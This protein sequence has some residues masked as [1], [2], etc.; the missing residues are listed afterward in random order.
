MSTF[1][2]ELCLTVKAGNGGPGCV[3]FRHEKFVEYGGPDGGDG[4]DGGNL[5]LQSTKILNSLSHLKPEKTYKAGSGSHGMGV[6]RSGKKGQD[7][8][9]E[10]PLGTQL[11]DPET[12]TVLHDFISEEKYVLAEGARGGKGNAFF[13]SATRQAPRFA[14]PGE[15]TESFEIVLRLKLIAEIGFV[16]L[17]NAGK[18]SLLSALTNAKPETAPYPFTTISPN[19]GVIEDAALGRVTLAD[20]PGIIE[21]ASKGLGLGLSFLK[22]MERVKLIIFVMDINSSDVPSELQ[23]LYKELAEYGKISADKARLLVL[24][25]IDLL[26][27]QDFLSEYLDSLADLN[28]P[29]MAVSAK[30]G[31]GINELRNKCLA[32]LR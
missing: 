25:K 12:E 5:Y 6:N 18:S 1:R 26:A 17:P 24:N 21:G 19:L 11:V 2:D 20:I 31:Q 27:D 29:I 14:Q 9:I 4:G 22:H 23:L 13:K 32:L 10:V 16:G 3:S 8:T 7:L 15:Q 30:S 28:M